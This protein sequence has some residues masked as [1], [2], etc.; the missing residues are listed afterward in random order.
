MEHLRT[1]LDLF[2]WTLQNSVSSRTRC[3][4][5][6]KKTLNDYVLKFF[7]CFL[8]FSLLSFVNEPTAI[9]VHLIHVNLLEMGLQYHNVAF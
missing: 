9:T 2:L 7:I 6:K 1:S 3:S 4:C 8:W 5:L